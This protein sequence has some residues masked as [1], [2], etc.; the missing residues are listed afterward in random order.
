METYWSTLGALFLLFGVFRD[1]SAG[2]SGGPAEMQCPVPDGP[3][4]CGILCSHD[5]DCPGGQK[6]CSI[7]CGVDCTVPILVKPGGC[8]PSF[9]VAYGMPCSHDGDCPGEQKCCKSIY[10]LKCKYPHLVSPKR[11]R[12]FLKKK[13][14]VGPIMRTHSGGTPL[15]LRMMLAIRFAR[16]GLGSSIRKLRW[17]ICPNT[18]TRPHFCLQKIS[19]ETYWST[20]G[21]LFLLVGVFRDSSAGFSGEPDVQCPNIDGPLHCAEFC[22]DDS[23]CPGRQKCCSNGCGHQCT[24][25]ILVKPGGCG[26]SFYV[27]Y[28]MPCSHDGDCPGEQKCCKSIN[29]LKCKYPH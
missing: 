20:L 22:V 1:S 6:C 29:G 16:P 25:P 23:D 11:K 8:G 18:S 3:S 9:Y 21:A 13:K 12:V 28:G 15:I 17:Y 2:F 4:H 26:P 7:G 24:V 27:A 10:G 5:S 19:M 14:S